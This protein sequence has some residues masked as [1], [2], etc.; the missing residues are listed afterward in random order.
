MPVKRAYA[1]A[2]LAVLLVAQPAA[3]GSDAP[4]ESEELAAKQRGT[5][6]HLLRVQQERFEADAR[7]D[8]PRKLKRLER[9]FRRTQLR[10]RE[11]MQAAEQAKRS[12]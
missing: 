3:A 1:F 10:R 5:E 11:L 12:D 8:D 7:G 6:R 4:T 9:E 2:L